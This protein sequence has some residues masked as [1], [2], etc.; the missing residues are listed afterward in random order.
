MVSWVLTY[1]I[2]IVSQFIVNYS[3]PD[4]VALKSLCQWEQGQLRNHYCL[5]G[6]DSVS[7]NRDCS[8][9]IAVGGG[10]ILSVGTGTAQK[11]LLSLGDW[12]CQWE[13]GQ[14]RNHC[15]LWGIDS[16]SG[17]RYC[18]EIIA[19]GGGL[20]LSVGTGTAQKSLLWEGDWFCFWLWLNLANSPPLPQMFSQ[21]WA[22]PPSIIQY[23]LGITC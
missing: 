20:I 17:N 12:F 8:E 18:S 23:N 10:L 5:W 6:I 1:Y 13:Q 15:C 14:L 21:H 16:V 3:D 2:S 11:S 9:I 19:M 7:G 22:H 4:N